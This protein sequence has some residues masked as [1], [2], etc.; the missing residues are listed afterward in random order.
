MTASRRIRS[1]RADKANILINREKAALTAGATA[2]MGPDFPQACPTER[3]TGREIINADQALILQSLRHAGPKGG[4]TMTELV[5]VERERNGLYRGSVERAMADLRERE[6][7]IE[8]TPKQHGRIVAKWG[9]SIQG[10]RAE[11]EYTRHQQKLADRAAAAPPP[12]FNTK[13]S[14]Y[15]PPANVFYR[16]NGNT[17]IPSLGVRC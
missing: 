6:L 15:T 17:H 16:N 11:V 7:V 14:S 9:A 4:L 10:R 8:L 3:R 13:G 1:P 2:M 12:T 5:L